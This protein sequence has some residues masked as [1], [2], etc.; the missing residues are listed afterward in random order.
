MFAAHGAAQPGVRDAV[1]AQDAHSAVD[2]A[3][4]LDRR[5]RS[6]LHS[7]YSFINALLSLNREESTR[8][9]TILV[10]NTQRLIK[11][12]AL[13]MFSVLLQKAKAAPPGGVSAAMLT[14]LGALASVGGEDARAYLPELMPA[15]VAGLADAS[16]TKREAALSALGRVCSSTGYVIAPLVDYPGLLPL[17]G[18]ILKADAGGERSG[19]GEAV[20]REVVKVMGVLGAMDPYR[21]KVSRT[22]ALCRQS[23]EVGT[24][25]LGGRDGERDFD[26]GEQGSAYHEYR[27]VLGRLLPDGGRLGPVARPQ[28]SRVERASSYCYRSDHVDLQDAGT[29]VRWEP[30]PGMH[31]FFPF[32]FSMS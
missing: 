9:L 21:R 2:G 32:R 3:R 17:L 8:L 20:K 16:I 14:C 12:Y 30:P 27:D 25:E 26:G 19:A 6:C 5:V 31:A 1:A 13:P 11:P 18:R 10:Y 22:N 7:W 24:D 23:A 15:L 29:E 28:G 4:V